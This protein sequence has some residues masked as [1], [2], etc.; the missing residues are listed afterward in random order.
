MSHPVNNDDS[1]TPR[2]RYV[3]HLCV[4]NPETGNGGYIARIRPW[5]NRSGDAR[6]H[7]GV[8]AD[9]CELIAAIN[10]LLPPGS[11]VR[12]I[13]GHVESPTGFYYLL[14]LTIAEA[15]RLGWSS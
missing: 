12:D 4:V 9:D 11:D 6:T 14:H 15:I 2:R 1:A 7:E 10:P 8:F 5:P 3:V 13:F